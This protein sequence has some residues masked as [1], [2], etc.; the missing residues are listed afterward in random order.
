MRS[1]LLHAR[2]RWKT[3]GKAAGRNAPVQ[4]CRNSNS[5]RNQLGW[6]VQ[7]MS[8]TM[9]KCDAKNSLNKVVLLMIGVRM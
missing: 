9:M 1:C 4:F 6:A 8:E 3:P 5:S 2:A 7:I